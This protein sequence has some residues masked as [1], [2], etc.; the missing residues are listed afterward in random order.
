MILIWHEI[1]PASIRPLDNGEFIAITGVGNRASGPAARITE[2]YEIFLS[3]DGRTLTR[4]SRKILS[5]GDS[6]SLD[7]EELSS[8]T[9]VTIDDA[10]HL[11]YVGAAQEGSVNTVLGA[12]GT[13]ESSSLPEPLSDVDRRRHL[14]KPE[15]ESPSTPL[16]AGS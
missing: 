2:L 16:R 15:G 8:P 9:S 13:L 7:A 14:Y 1:D 12:T 3:E 4:Q 11:I 6:D 5:V 10:T